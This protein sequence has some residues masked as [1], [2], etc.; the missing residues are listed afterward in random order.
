MYAK[1]LV[2]IFLFLTLVLA[3]EAYSGNHSLIIYVTFAPGHGYL[4][5]YSSYGLL[6]DYRVFSYD[7]TK[8]DISSPFRDQ[9]S[10]SNVWRDLQHC[11]AFKTDYFNHFMRQ[12]NA[13]IG[14]HGPIL[15]LMYGCE[16][17]QDNKMKGV[18]EFSVN[19]KYTLSLDHDNTHW[20]THLPQAKDIKKILDGFILWNKSNQIYMQRDCVPRL[21][22]FYMHSVTTIHRQVSPEVVIAPSAEGPDTLTCVVTGFYPK[23]IT[24]EWALDGEP[25]SF[26]VLSTDVLPNHDL[27]YQIRKTLTVSAPEG[28]Y[29]CKV[30]HRSLPQPLVIHWGM[31]GLHKAQNAS[32]IITIHVG[33]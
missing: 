25:V 2:H 7:S 26:N 12:A 4:P 19:G 14:I 8:G 29:S 9:A 3:E 32:T 17:S 16:L 13:S 27:T 28:N 31:L 11:T 1:I 6:D 5:M 18:Y 10:L 30:E 23:D 20:T 24:V 33:S 21:K 22:Q 15:Q